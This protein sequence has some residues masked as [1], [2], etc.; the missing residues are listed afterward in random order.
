M[1]RRWRSG[2]SF[3]FGRLISDLAPGLVKHSNIE[4]DQGRDW[5]GGVRRSRL[6]A[7]QEKSRGGKGGNAMR[8][9]PKSPKIG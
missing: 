5:S 4:D 6:C 9:T 1:I 8:R 3:G 7:L 2:V